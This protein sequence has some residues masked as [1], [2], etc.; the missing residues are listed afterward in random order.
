MVLAVGV[1][2]GTGA[3]F[4]LVT[5]AFFKA[6][7]FLGAGSVIHALHHEQDI[8][9][10]GG[11]RRRM[12]ATYRSFL[13]G[14]LALCGVPP[15]SGFY[16]KDGILAAAAEGSPALFALATLVAV[17]T[18]F[19][20]FR[21]VF[22]AFLGSPR[23]EAA[24]QAHES[25]GVMV[26]P[27]RVLAFASV[28]AGF[29]GID[30]FLRGFFEPGIEPHA[31]PWHAHLLE[32]FNHSPLAALFGLFAVAIGFSAA[33]ACY[34]GAEKDPLPARLPLLTRVVRERFYLDEIYA[35]LIV[36][37]Q[38]ALARLADWLDRHVVAGF[39]VRG[40]HGSTEFA[41]RALRLLQTGNLQTYAFL[42]AAGVVLLLYFVLGG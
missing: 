1:A 28:F 34:A 26:W 24:G 11:L 21:L 10:M 13:I 7:L 8:W 35:A 33:R 4:H 40:S 25:P 38:D 19:Y 42:L 36:G 9:R 37:T 2:S 32:P 22:V 29:W 27:L 18:A 6:L 3:M 23:T 12:P 5:H 15:L 20:M 41:G 30:L 31:L 39:L 17:L 16:S 14:T